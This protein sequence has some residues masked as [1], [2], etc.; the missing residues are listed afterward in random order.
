MTANLVGTGAD[1]VGTRPGGMCLICVFIDAGNLDFRATKCSE[2]ESVKKTFAK[3]DSKSWRCGVY[4][5]NLMSRPMEVYMVLY[6][7]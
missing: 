4:S 2:A 3:N 6:L 1:Y 5:E 7:E